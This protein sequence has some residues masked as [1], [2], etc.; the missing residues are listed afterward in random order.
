MHV[1]HISLHVLSVFQ[2]LSKLQTKNVLSL[3]QGQNFAVLYSKTLPAYQY[4]QVH[5]ISVLLYDKD[6]YLPIL[7]P[8]CEYSKSLEKR[9][10]ET[11]VVERTMLLLT[12]YL[13]E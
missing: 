7:I 9:T 2:D 8:A 12:L 3:S 5:S 6:K 13:H 4:P 10:K 11:D 1:T